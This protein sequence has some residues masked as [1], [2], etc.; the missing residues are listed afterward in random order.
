MLTH[1][2]CHHTLTYQFTDFF[3]RELQGDLVDGVT[4]FADQV[5]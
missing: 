2:V 4:S 3:M 5:S 1:L